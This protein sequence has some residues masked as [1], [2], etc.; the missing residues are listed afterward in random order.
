MQARYSYEHLSVRPSV[1]LSVKHV[2]CDKTK[3]P[4]EKSSIMTNRKSATSF[5]ICLR[6]T[7]YI[8]PNPKG[9]LKG[10]HFFVFRIENGR[11]SN[12]ICYKVSLCE[13]FRRQSCKAFIGLSVRAQIVD[14]GYPFYLKF[15]TKVT[16]PFL[17]RRFQYIFARSSTSITASEKKFNYH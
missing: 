1:C 10:D 12:K 2:D 5:P 13:N 9:G 3:A 17:K 16:H 6:W 8:A 14:G 7:S 15:S 4:S 11:F